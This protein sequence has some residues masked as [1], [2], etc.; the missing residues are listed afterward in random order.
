MTT[1]TFSNYGKRRFDPQAPTSVLVSRRALELDIPDPAAW[2]FHVSLATRIDA[3][4]HA[5]MINPESSRSMHLFRKD[6]DGFADMVAH[7]IKSG[8]WI[9][10]F[11]APKQPEFVGMT[12]EDIAAS[13]ELAGETDFQ[14]MSH[15]AVKRFVL[16]KGVHEIDHY[17]PTFLDSVRADIDRL[18]KVWGSLNHIKVLSRYTQDEADLELG[19]ENMAPLYIRPRFNDLGF[20]DFGKTPLNYNDGKICHSTWFDH[21][22]MSAKKPDEI[23]QLASI[24]SLPDDMVTKPFSA[25]IPFGDI[26]KK[27]DLGENP[28]KAITNAIRKIQAAGWFTTAIELSSGND[29]FG[30]ELI[31]TPTKKLHDAVWDFELHPGGSAQTLWEEK[32]GHLPAKQL[33][34]GDDPYENLPKLG[35]HW[36]YL[37]KSSKKGYLT[38]GQ[39]TVPLRVRLSQ[40]Q[41]Y[42]SNGTIDKIIR[43]ISDDHDDLLEIEYIGQV[44][45]DHCSEFEM[46][47]LWKMRELGHKMYNSL[48]TIEGN[49]HTIYLDKRFN[50]YTPRDQKFMLLESKEYFGATIDLRHL[51][52]YEETSIASRSAEHMAPF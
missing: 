29:D 20:R 14:K 15:E 23:Q 4:S 18:K 44:H 8:H 33:V 39:T 48:D 22:L 17:I 52:A 46:R 19:I 27:F 41:T 5:P 2:I 35:F 50:A 12:E 42:A 40:H 7:L 51:P 43:D 21:P 45:H 31:L 25:R 6:E 1:N 38:V 9:V 3:S 30:L 28:T 49:A 10:V 26:A 37:L 36:L 11:K 13:I 32:N 16:N 34:E 47:A 24:R